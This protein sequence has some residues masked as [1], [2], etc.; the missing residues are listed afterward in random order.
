VGLTGMHIQ[1]TPNPRYRR[2]TYP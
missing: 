2:I 1:L